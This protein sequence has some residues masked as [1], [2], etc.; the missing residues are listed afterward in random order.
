MDQNG[1]RRSGYRPYLASP[2][3]TPQPQ[4]ARGTSSLKR[5]RTPDG[6]DE[7]LNRAEQQV[8][9]LQDQLQTAQTTI[10]NQEAEIERLQ[11]DAEQ[12]EAASKG[13]I[14]KS[15]KNEENPDEDSAN[16]M[17]QKFD[18]DL[19]H[20]KRMKDSYRDKVKKKDL[21]I[22]KKEKEIESRG[23]QIKERDEKI[24]Q[25]EEQYE[26]N[27]KAL[28]EVTDLKSKIKELE[29]EHSAK[30]QEL[31]YDVSQLT[32]KN[33]KRKRLIQTLETVIEQERA[34]MGTLQATTKDQETWIN[35]LKKELHEVWI[36][37][38]QQVNAYR[39]MEAQGGAD[40]QNLKD[41]WNRR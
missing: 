11:G 38:N 6:N 30:V 2:R 36:L 33:D 18:L 9:T 28:A 19:R 17:L 39:K 20:E 40:M 37:L 25:L 21:D 7:S 29:Q 15:I 8:K 16:E 12:A 5:S 35:N 13:D 31:E 14:K 41:R 4:I 23:K 24:E 22:K 3:S 1:E 32:D 34:A 10:Q 27:T 26:Q